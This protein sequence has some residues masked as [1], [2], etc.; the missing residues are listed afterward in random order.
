MDFAFDFDAIYVHYGKSPQALQAFSDLN[1]P[2]MDGLSGLDLIMCFQDPNRNRPHSTYTSFDGLMDGLDYQGYRQEI[3][4]ELDAKFNFAEEEINLTSGE[5]ATLVELPFSYY[6][7]PWFEYDKDIKMYKRFQYDEK[8]IDIE[9]GEQLEFKNIIVQ[10]ADMWVIPGD[11][12]GRLDMSLVSSGKGYYIT[13]GKYIPI[14]WE[15]E[16]HYEPTHYYLDNGEELVMN[17]GKT[18][19]SVFPEYQTSE[20]I[21]E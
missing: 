4:E 19:I 7:S 20:I 5:N 11:S 16:S 12:E 1:A 18:W 9:T 15:K 21:F 13:N 17:P 8:H 6:H 10:I 3:N 2:N 14:T